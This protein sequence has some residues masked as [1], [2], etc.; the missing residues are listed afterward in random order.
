[1]RLTVAKLKPVRCVEEGSDSR[2]SVRTGVLYCHPCLSGGEKETVNNDTCGVHCETE[3]EL[4]KCSGV[5]FVTQALRMLLKLTS[6]VKTPKNHFE[7]QTAVC[8]KMRIQ[9]KIILYSY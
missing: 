8:S 9:P 1:M 7:H 2:T 6:G 3:A 5:C 4:C